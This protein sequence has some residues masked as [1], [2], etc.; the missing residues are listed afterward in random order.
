MKDLRNK[1]VLLLAFLNISILIYLIIIV[2]TLPKIKTQ[3]FYPTN[4]VTILDS[5]NNLINHLP[6]FKSDITYEEIPQNVINALIST[7]DEA[8]FIHNG[9]NPKRII[10][11]ILTDIKSHYAKEGASTITQQVIKNTYLSSEKNINRKVK[12]IILAIKLENSMQK[13]DIITYY[14]N[15]VLFS[16]N[17]YG[18]YNA[19]LYFF[20]KKPALLTVDEAAMLVGLIQLPNKYNPYKNLAEATIRRDIVLKAMYKNNFLTHDELEIYRNIKL[21]NKLKKNVIFQNTSYY[22][23]YLDLIDT[24]TKSLKTYMNKDIQYTLYEIA[25]N[26]LGFLPDDKINIGLIAIDNHT[27]GILGIFGNRT[28]NKITINN[29][30][31]KRHM[32][33]TMKPLID[34][35]P[36][37]EKTT[38]SPGEVVIDEEYNYSD[39]TSLKNW[40]SIYKGAI[41][42]RQALRE[43]RNIPA[44]KIFK[45]TSKETK[46]ETLSRLGLTVPNNLYEADAIGCGNGLYSLFE[47]S[48]AYLAFANNGKFKK[49]SYILND[50]PFLQVIKPSSAFFINSILHD[51]FS[52]SKF[53]P[54]N[55]YMMAKTGQTN[56]DK[57]TALKYNI[58]SNATKESFVISYT[59]DITFGCYVGYDK[60]DSTSYLDRIKTQIPRTIMTYF[61]NKFQTNVGSPDTP[62]NIEKQKCIIKDNVLYLDESGIYEYFI[63]DALPP[64]Y[65]EHN[66]IKI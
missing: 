58:P 35:L 56:Y 9:I 34:Y 53:V 24:K 13:S 45:K 37:F 14:L 4:D 20:N 38:A 48:N 28:A 12:E 50:D 43:S 25:T 8:F 10:K 26:K 30:L 66:Y 57:R 47:I 31:V 7:E 17:I 33:S 49:A 18:I 61:M 6:T 44:L 15:N 64:K 5:N 2:N 52:K 40:D 3:D 1:L 16:D 51:V 59:K 29:V 19:S 62:S 39:G 22:N 32:A 41:S 27:A 11:A 21:E 36:Y 55:T 65:K 23:P 42:L 46:I 63:K 54:K 60:I